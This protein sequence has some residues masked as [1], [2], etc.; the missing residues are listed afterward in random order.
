L[1]GA[2]L[3]TKKMAQQIWAT[4]PVKLSPIPNGP[5]Y[6][7]TMQTSATMIAHNAKIQKAL[8]STPVGHLVTG[9]KKDVVIC[10]HLLQDPSRV[11]I[12]GWFY[13]TGQAIQGLNPVSHDKLYKDYSHGIRFVHRTMLL[14][15]SSVDYFDLLKDSAHASLISDEGPFDASHI[16]HS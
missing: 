11:A 7:E 13:P 14:N 2:A 5:P 1:F 12:Y 8:G 6:D 16:Y 9:H 3:P 15:G 10:T 4:A